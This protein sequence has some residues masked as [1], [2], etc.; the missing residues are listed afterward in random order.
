MGRVMRKIHDH[1]TISE[2]ESLLNMMEY[3]STYDPDKE[4]IIRR[5]LNFMQDN[6]RLNL[7]SRQINADKVYLN[8]QDYIFDSVAQVMRSFL[9]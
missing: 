7:F 5:G 6:R 4:W 8:K 9:R 1:T 3:V 2:F